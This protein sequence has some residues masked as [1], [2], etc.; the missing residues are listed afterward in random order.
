MLIHTTA[1]QTTTLEPELQSPTKSMSKTLHGRAFHWRSLDSPDSFMIP[2]A[3]NVAEK[4]STSYRCANEAVHV[5]SPSKTESRRHFMHTWHWRT[6]LG[7][8]KGVQA[9]VW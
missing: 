6:S 3:S 2:L 9:L 1:R 4:G 7:G 8:C 5:R